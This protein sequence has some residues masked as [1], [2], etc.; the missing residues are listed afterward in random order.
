MRA[1][2]GVIV[3]IITTTL[4]VASGSA[5]HA[6]PGPSLAEAQ[7]RLSALE[8]QA[9]IASEEYNRAEQ[10]LVQARSQLARAT[11]R[12]TATEQELARLQGEAAEIA[13]HAYMTGAGGLGTMLRLLLADDAESDLA[14]AVDAQQIARSQTAAIRRTQVQQL[15]LARAQAAVTQAEQEQ[16]RALQR[17]GEHQRAIES[18]VAEARSVVSSLREADRR[19]LEQRAAQAR[20]ASVAAARD[21]DRASRSRP[22]AATPPG[23]SDTTPPPRPS[24]STRA[25]KAVRYALAQ[26]GEPYSYSAR[27]PDSWDCSKLTSRA[28]AS[29]GVSL[30]P[31]S[32]AQ[33]QQ[34]TRIPV[35]EL[36]PGDLLFYFNNARHVAMYIGGGKLVEAASPEN[37]V[38]VQDAWNSW[39]KAHFSFAGRPG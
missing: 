3:A 39:S 35:S 28:W 36:R 37:G 26:V 38:Q 25:T 29:A 27:P 33:A 31:Y 30:T 6:E 15:A 10:D 21:A 11:S 18:S 2:T 4:V 22:R 32:L 17:M 23:G 1:R 19:A 20:Q 12:L 7:T 34:V 16:S 13:A 5:G 8:N 24:G 9:E 14:S